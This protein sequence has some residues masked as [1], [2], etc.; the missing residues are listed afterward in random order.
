MKLDANL[1]ICIGSITATILMVII[2]KMEAGI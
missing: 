1:A 2:F